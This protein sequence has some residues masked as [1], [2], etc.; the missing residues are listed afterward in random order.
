MVDGGLTPTASIPSLLE[1]SA[2]QV[3]AQNASAIPQTKVCPHLRQEEEEMAD[4]DEH[5]QRASS[6]VSK[7]REG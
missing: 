7:K 5:T 3:Q 1:M 2:P 4:I 6:P